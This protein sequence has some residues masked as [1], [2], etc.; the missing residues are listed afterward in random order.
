MNNLWHQR[1]HYSVHNNPPLAPI[2]SQINIV[3]TTLFYLSK[4]QSYYV[5]LEHTALL[6]V[7]SGMKWQSYSWPL[8]G[9]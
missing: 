4:I 6:I 3:L 2:L 1:V 8:V 9:Q 5:L 7:H